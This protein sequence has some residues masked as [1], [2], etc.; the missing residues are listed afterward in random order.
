[1][2]QFLDQR[3]RLLQVFRVKALGE[4]VVNL[5]QELVRFGFFALRLP[6]TSKAGRRAQLPR[7]GLLALRDF[8]GFAET[9]L[10]LP[11]YLAWDLGLETWGLGGRGTGL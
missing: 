11:R 6:Q 5:R 4:P 1:M 2:T 10:R 8:D 9:H 3:L 7:F